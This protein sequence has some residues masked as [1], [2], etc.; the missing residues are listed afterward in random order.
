MPVRVDPRGNQWCVVKIETGETEKC[1][2]SKD[3]AQSYATALNMTHSRA[4]GYIHGER[5]LADSIK[6]ELSEM[7]DIE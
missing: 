5:P 1:Y 4:K 2:D 6:E 3:E 7:H